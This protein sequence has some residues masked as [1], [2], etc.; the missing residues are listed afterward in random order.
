MKIKTLAPWFLAFSCTTPLF[1]NN[2]Q[3]QFDIVNVTGIELYGV[4]VS[5]TASNEW[6]DDI[7]PFDTFSDGVTVTVSIPVDDETLCTY[8]I[9]VTDFEDN[10]RV[11][12]EIDFCDVSNLTF[13]EGSDGEIYYRTE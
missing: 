13:F 1:A 4:Y 6:G 8:D 9:M 5:E 7:I 11:F 2:L 10:A 3:L 12:P